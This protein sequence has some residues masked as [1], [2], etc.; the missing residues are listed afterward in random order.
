MPKGNGGKIIQSYLG[1]FKAHLAKAIR[2]QLGPVSSPAQLQVGTPAHK[3]WAQWQQSGIHTW[4]FKSNDRVLSFDNPVGIE[5]PDADHEVSSSKF[6]RRAS[7]AMRNK[8]KTQ[9]DW[10]KRQVSERIP[11]AEYIATVNDEKD[12]PPHLHQIISPTTTTP[13]SSNLIEMS[14]VDSD[15]ESINIEER[16]LD[17]VIEDQFDH[18]MFL[19]TPPR[20]PPLDQSM[21]IAPAVDIARNIPLPPSPMSSATSLVETKQDRSYIDLVKV[22]CGIL[23][24][25][26]DKKPSSCMD[27]TEIIISKHYYELYPHIPQLIT[28]LGGS[29]FIDS[30]SP[31]PLTCGVQ[32]Y[33][34]DID[35]SLGRNGSSKSNTLIDD[36][37]PKLDFH[38][39]FN[40]IRDLREKELSPGNDDNG[41]GDLLTF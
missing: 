38:G 31:K 13:S 32:R 18:T 29:I 25:E 33:A 17:I 16:S 28:S 19:H 41:S 2:S 8:R 11:W 5:S 23:K 14:S 7:T 34:I 22:L 1:Y 3:A 15:S 4:Y 35:W 6:F 37:S 26:L 21:I 12:F 36:E 27:K 20:V 10:P 39:L 40:L 9:E 30:K 24:L